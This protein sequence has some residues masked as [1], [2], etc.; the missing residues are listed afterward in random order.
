MLRLG[1]KKN[2]TAHNHK[3]IIITWQY[4]RKRPKMTRGI[5]PPTF[6]S[7]PPAD[8]IVL[9][10]SCFWDSSSSMRVVS[11]CKWHVLL[12]STVFTPYDS[13]NSRH[14]T[15]THT[16]SNP[17]PTVRLGSRRISVHFTLVT[18]KAW[19]TWPT[20]FS[21]FETNYLYTAQN[22]YQFLELNGCHT[23]VAWEVLRGLANLL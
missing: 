9:S 19:P 6:S 7:N 21:Q 1:V 8:I 3:V 4:Y 10:T 22:Y 17:S 20:A 11:S 12:S 5:N 18:K 15:R 16:Q 23:A 13:N 2:N 14:N